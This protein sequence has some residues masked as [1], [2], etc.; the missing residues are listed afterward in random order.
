[1]AELVHGGKEHSDWFPERSKFYHIRTVKVDRS[2]T[3]LT[4]MCSSKD[5]QN[6]LSG[7]KV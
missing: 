4:D 2:R 1:M 7:Q 6:L 3:D 5:I